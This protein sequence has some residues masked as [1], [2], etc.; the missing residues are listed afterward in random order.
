[1]AKIESFARPRM[2]GYGDWW[3]VLSGDLDDEFEAYVGLE[4]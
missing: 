2:S 1:M 4:P 3:G